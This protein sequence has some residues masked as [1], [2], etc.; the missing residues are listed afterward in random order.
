[1]SHLDHIDLLRPVEE[2]AYPPDVIFKTHETPPPARGWYEA[3]IRH[4][5]RDYFAYWDGTH[6]VDFVVESDGG[7]RHHHRTDLRDRPDWQDNHNIWWRNVH[8]M[9]EPE[10]RA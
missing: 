3:H 2:N 4:V 7:K 8:P 6:W 5:H 1:M 10:P 9:R